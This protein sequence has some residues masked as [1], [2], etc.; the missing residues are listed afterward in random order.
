M[1][2][3][4]MLSASFDAI[5]PMLCVTAGALVIMLA[6]AWREPGERMPLGVWGIISL[7]GAAIGLLLLWDRNAASFDVIVA[8]NFG[9]FVSL[10]LAAVGVLTILFSS[11]VLERDGI[12]AGEYYAILLFGLAGMM[13]MAMAN[14]L[15][16]IFIALEI[17]SLSVYVLTG[18]RRESLPGVEGAL[19]YFLLGSF[20]SAFFLYGV[21]FTYG[22][23][24][25]TRLDRVGAY[26]AAQS[27]SDSPLILLAL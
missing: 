26:L 17:L 12:P 16:V 25:S 20:S 13:M 10:I 3:L 1:T 6:E 19:K 2:E 24:G 22:I 21:A 27:M 7:A 15:L 14:D 23:T 18:I 11:Q 5:V 9:I 4:Q 8:D